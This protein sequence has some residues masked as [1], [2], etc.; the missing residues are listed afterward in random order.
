MKSSRK[1]REA[2]LK[3][4]EDSHIESDQR[5]KMKVVEEHT[6]ELDKHI[7]D[8]EIEM[9]KRC[10][11]YSVYIQGLMSIPG[12]SMIAAM[13][14]IAE[15]GTDMSVFESEATRRRSSLSPE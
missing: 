12:I 7:E 2:I 5:L 15:I 13:I 9:V 11:S 6:A 10:L 4:L 14:I 8:L 3:S 1:K